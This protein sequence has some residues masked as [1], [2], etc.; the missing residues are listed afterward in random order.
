METN[1][2]SFEI[3]AIV[4][5][6]GVKVAEVK[7]IVNGYEL[8][9]APYKNGGFTLNLPS[10][11]SAQYL[12]KE[13]VGIAS[14]VN[15][16]TTDFARIEAYNKTTP[17]GS[18][19]FKTGGSNTGKVISPFFYVDRDVTLNGSYPHEKEEGKTLTCICNN[20]S[21]KKGWTKT[22]SISETNSSPNGVTTKLTTT[23]QSG[24]EWHFDT[25]E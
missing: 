11:V 18:F 12:K 14:D 9:V 5:T 2:D 20:V 23:E 10:T 4:D 13:A 15:V 17:V 19:L 25:K 1:K 16:K 7:V 8:A 6:H 22:Y 3:T 21:L 24:L